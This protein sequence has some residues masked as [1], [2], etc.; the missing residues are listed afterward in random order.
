MPSEVWALVLDGR[1]IKPSML[2]ASYFL[3]DGDDWL[4]HILKGTAFKNSSFA[5]TAALDE[6]VRKLHTDLNAMGIQPIVFLD[7]VQPKSVKSSRPLID[8]DNQR[9]QL[10]QL[11]K[12]LKSLSVDIEDCDSIRR[13]GI[14]VDFFR[15]MTA[16]GEYSCYIYG[17]SLL[18]L[19][20]VKGVPYILFDTL[21]ITDAEK[22]QAPVWT[23]AIVAAALFVTESQ[24]T[25]LMILVGNRYTKPFGRKGYR[26]AQGG[27]VPNAFLDIENDESRGI[28]FH[29]RE[30]KCDDMISLA[31]MRD[32][33]L[34]Q[35]EDFRLRFADKFAPSVESP[36][37]SVHAAIEFS[38]VYYNNGDSIALY[39]AMELKKLSAAATD[40]AR[41]PAA[42]AIMA[43]I[44]GA[45]A[46]PTPAPAPSSNSRT[47][48]IT[49]GKKVTD[50][51]IYDV[52]LTESEEKLQ[53]RRKEAVKKPSER[54]SR[55][56]GREAEVE[57]SRKVRRE[58]GDI[59]EKKGRTETSN[60]VLV[61]VAATSAV[62][63]VDETK[64]TQLR[65]LLG[66]KFGLKQ[67]AIGTSPSPDTVLSESPAVHPKASQEKEK[68]SIPAPT[69]APLT[70]QSSAVTTA[71]VAVAAAV[72]SDAMECAPKVCRG[73]E[74]QSPVPTRRLLMGGSSS[75][76]KQSPSSSLSL[77]SSSRPPVVLPIDAHKSEI[78]THIAA[79]SVTIIHGSTGCGKSSR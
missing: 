34:L 10:V 64:G 27:G 47:V 23:K 31:S 67:P 73:D 17:S 74:S 65:N 63:N 19:W 66:I 53:S 9:A 18:D 70:G 20:A 75:S 60:S 21:S 36:F 1:R 79:N 49:S 29:S 6:S 61:P 52:K 33:M 59:E 37:S 24:L 40:S 30:P 62:V 71:A 46:A 41:Q 32:W 35:G 55:D 57:V 15:T 77:S 16:R 78:L 50:S 8:Y 43:A 45:S 68:E 12:T 25:E 58:K 2:P 26:S 14:M 44:S 4:A 38:R 5:T 22:V 72:A 39:N 3:V 7:K 11:R 42:A 13:A 28:K 54:K 56:V 51:S 76:S 69:Q 48:T